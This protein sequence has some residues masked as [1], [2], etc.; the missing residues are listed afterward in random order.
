MADHPDIVIV[1]GVSAAARPPRRWR[2][3][4][5]APV[6]ERD[7]QAHDRVRGEFMASWRVAEAAELTLSAR[8]ATATGS[9]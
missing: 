1:G 4:V 6:L 7:L 8:C 2:D 9:I 3:G 5:S